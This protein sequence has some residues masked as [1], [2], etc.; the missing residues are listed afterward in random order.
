MQYLFF[1]IGL[2]NILYLVVCGLTLFIALQLRKQSRFHVHRLLY[3]FAG[4]FGVFAVF[5]DLYRFKWLRNRLLA[6]FRTVALYQYT[7]SAIALVLILGVLLW[8]CFN[9][10]L[11]RIE[12]DQ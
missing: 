9:F 4:Y 10:F 1:N 8:F 7:L 12:Y 5:S 6:Q 11:K 3:G 2:L